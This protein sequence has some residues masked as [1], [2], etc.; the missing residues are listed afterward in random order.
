MDEEFR[1]MF[2]ENRDKSRPIRLDAK[3]HMVKV[4]EEQSK[5]HNL[6]RK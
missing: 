2:Q 6:R 4:Q 1:N 5:T 3:E